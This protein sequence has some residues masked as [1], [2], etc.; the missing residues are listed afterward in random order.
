LN[1][2]KTLTVWAPAKAITG[3][4]TPEHSYMAQ[5]Q[6]GWAEMQERQWPATLMTP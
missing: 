5:L 3:S 4:F 1:W 2:E 6:T